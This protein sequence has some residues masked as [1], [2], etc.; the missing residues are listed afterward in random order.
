[1]AGSLLP[2]FVFR[3]LDA[4]GLAMSGAQ[5]FFYQ[6]G[7]LTPQSVYTT[8]AVS[9]A[10]PNP[11]VADSGG[12]FPPIYPNPAQSYR[13]ILKTAGGVTI[14]DIDPVIAPSVIASGSITAAMLA[15]GAAVSNIGYTPLNKAGDTPTGE[16]VLGYTMAAPPADKSAGFRGMPVI[17][18]DANYTFV[19]EDSGK[20][21][22][23]SDANSYAWTV[24][25]H[26]SVAYQPGTIIGFSSGGGTITITRGSGVAIFIA[27]VG[28][29]QNIALAPFSMGALTNLGTDFWV[30]TGTG[31]S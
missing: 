17:Y 4:N 9:V 8:S 22:R 13:A 23:H 6:T 14:Q 20:L 19:A 10:H 11:L 21:Y 24:P 3:A 15:S 12:L 29:N 16:I 28:T 30:W 27:G 2:E 26:S 1:M 5:L 25:P 7:T 18:K 31:G